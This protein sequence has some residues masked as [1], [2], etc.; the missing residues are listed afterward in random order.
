MHLHFIDD[1]D[2][3]IIDVMEFCSDFCHQD[4]LGVE[5]QGW[6]GCH[7]MQHDTTCQNCGEIL[8][9]ESIEDN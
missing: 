5:Y 6:N 4:A 1:L 8:H 2:G 9:V 7:E 3:N